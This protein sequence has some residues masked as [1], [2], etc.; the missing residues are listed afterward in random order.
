MGGDGYAQLRAESDT[1]LAELDSSENLARSDLPRRSPSDIFEVSL[2]YV[3]ACIKL[4]FVRQSS[5]LST[6]SKCR[7]QSRPNVMRCGFI[8]CVRACYSL[9]LKDGF[10][11][12]GW[13]ETVDRLV[14]YQQNSGKY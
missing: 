7:R 11:L 4:V 2:Q 5:S 3:E 9:K 10:E 12:F 6:P 13:E 14:N 8:R 1:P